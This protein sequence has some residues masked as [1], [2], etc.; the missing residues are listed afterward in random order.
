MECET[1][2]KLA[3]RLP[4]TFRALPPGCGDFEF[5]VY[6]RTLNDHIQSS[7]S[8]DEGASATMQE[9]EVTTEIIPLLASRGLQVRQCKV[10]PEAYMHERV[11][12]KLATDNSR[13]QMPYSEGLMASEVVRA[14]TSYGCGL[15]EAITKHTHVSVPSWGDVRCHRNC[16]KGL[17]DRTEI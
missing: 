2:N 9:E 13:K 4:P 3:A 15:P 12:H 17:V 16:T 10:H 8:P 6:N 7:V 1:T 5:P 14:P 11:V